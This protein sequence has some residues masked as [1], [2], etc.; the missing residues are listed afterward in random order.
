MK[1]TS[2]FMVQK[3]VSLSYV[4]QSLD[5]KHLREWKLDE[6]IVGPCEILVGF[7]T[8]TEAMSIIVVDMAEPA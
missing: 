6:P 4:Q 5:G 3:G 1:R 8:D 2:S 7:D